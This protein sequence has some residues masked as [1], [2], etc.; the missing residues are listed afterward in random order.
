MEVHHPHHIA[1][2]KKWSE[3]IIEFILLFTA[4]TL[5]FFAEN[6]RE[7]Q[8]EIHKTE[9][10]LKTLY[11][12]IQKDSILFSTALPRRKKADSLFEVISKYY[13][14]GE[15]KSHLIE[16]YA[17]LGQISNRSMPNINNMALDEV[18]NTGRITFIEDDNLIN[19][20][21]NYSHFA[22]VLESREIREENFLNQFID[23]IRFKY[24]EQNILYALNYDN[25][26]V[27]GD[28]IVTKPSK[29]LP[30]RIYLL[31]EKIFNE[32]SF[33]NITG[34]MN[35]VIKR[36][37]ELRVEPAQH[38]C[39]ELLHLLRSYFNKIKFDYNLVNE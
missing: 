14:R 34:G 21:Q 27:R 26:F 15:L 3:Y 10:S 29:T 8:V 4:V 11:R 16:C 22:K 1:H 13:E 23:P 35:N 28:S 12:D 36:S 25:A 9:K 7:H 24:F 2:K 37:N 33:I 6:I 30:K 18:K 20:I 19:A 39:H 17:F 31:E 5:G 38:Q 32:A